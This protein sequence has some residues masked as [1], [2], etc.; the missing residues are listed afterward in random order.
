[1]P[2]E[3][4]TKYLTT[5]IQ[6]APVLHREMV[7]EVVKGYKDDKINFNDAENVV[8]LLA[9]RNTA[10][11]RSGRATTAYRNLML[12]SGA[13]KERGPQS[14]HQ[15]LA[16]MDIDRHRKHLKKL[17]AEIESKGPER[18]VTVI[19]YT[20]SEKKGHARGPDTEELTE[21]EKK[22]YRK[23]LNKKWKGLHQFWKGQLTIKGG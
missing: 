11:R 14:V 15:R 5:Y 13:I 12:K 22:Q 21:Q 6:S 17:E 3:R 9:S 2:I 1:M 19:L 20:T 4:K 18:M 7:R 23:Y 16:Q 8:L 10:L